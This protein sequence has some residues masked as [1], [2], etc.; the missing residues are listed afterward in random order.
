MRKPSPVGEAEC[1]I[2]RP[3]PSRTGAGAT[4]E[5][6]SRESSPVGEVERCVGKPSPSRT[7]AGATPERGSLVDDVAGTFGV[8]PWSDDEVRR[9]QSLVP[10]VLHTLYR[11]AKTLDQSKV[12]LAQTAALWGRDR[13]LDGCTL[14]MR[15][16]TASASTAGDSRACA[17]AFVLRL[18]AHVRA[19]ASLHLRFCRRHHHHRHTAIASSILPA[20]THAFPHPHARATSMI[21]EKHAHSG[22]PTWSV[23]CNARATCETRHATCDSSACAGRV[24]SRVSTLSERVPL[25]YA[26]LAP[27][28]LVSDYAVVAPLNAANS[29]CCPHSLL[30][31]DS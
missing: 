29:L 30:R 2:G 6:G 1:F 26:I 21:R 22:R 9:T 10:K 18:R 25:G 4:P 3:S 24:L 11:R 7:G 15:V 5:R 23:T 8:H 27:L 17:L 28:R 16:T 13:M 12:Q 31:I 20:L 19:H 14:L